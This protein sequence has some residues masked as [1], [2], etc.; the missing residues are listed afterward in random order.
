MHAFAI[1]YGT[2]LAALHTHGIE[3]AL[4][5]AYFGAD[6]DDLLTLFVETDNLIR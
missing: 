6:N 2:T 3:V 1:A 4:Q 5:G